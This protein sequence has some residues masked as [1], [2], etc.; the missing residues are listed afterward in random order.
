MI[1]MDKETDV[2]YQ[3]AVTMYK[4]PVEEVT[5]D[6]QDIIKT[7]YYSIYYSGT[8]LLEYPKE[9]QNAIKTANDNRPASVQSGHSMYLYDWVDFNRGGPVGNG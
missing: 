7:T 3:L 5:Q 8:P 4:K 1:I 2:Y 9:L 6:E